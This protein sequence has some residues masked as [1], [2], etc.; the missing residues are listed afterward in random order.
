[1]RMNEDLKV[2]LLIAA[3]FFGG[4]F[5]IGGLV[6]MIAYPLDAATCTAHWRDSGYKSD[7]SFWGDC[8]ISK[9][10]K[11]WIPEKAYRQFKNEQS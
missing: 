4:M 8:R 9:D 7:F 2:F 3:V 5:T 6:T 10:G 1:M 11:T